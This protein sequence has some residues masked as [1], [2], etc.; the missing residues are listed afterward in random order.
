M[1]VVPLSLDPRSEAT[2]AAIEDMGERPLAHN[3]AQRQRDPG[4]P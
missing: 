2:A 1:T 4:D 3:R